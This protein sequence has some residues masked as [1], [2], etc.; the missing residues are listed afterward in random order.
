MCFLGYYLEHKCYH[1]YDPVTYHT[2]ISYDVTFMSLLLFMIL[3]LLLSIHLPWSLCSSF[4]LPL[5][6]RMF[7]LCLPVLHHLTFF[8]SFLFTLLLTSFLL[9]LLSLLYSIILLSLFLLLTL[10]FVSH[11]TAGIP[12]NLY[13]GWSSLTPPLLSIR[14]LRYSLTLIL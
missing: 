13:L 6:L 10:L 11:T 14:L 1:C 3:F 7:P 12:Q 8:Q 2:R 4:S 5:R 9:Y